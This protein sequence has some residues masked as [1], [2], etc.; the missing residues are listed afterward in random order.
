MKIVPHKLVARRLMVARAALSALL[1]ASFLIPAIPFTAVAAVVLFWLTLSSDKRS[2]RE[3]LMISAPFLFLGLVGLAMSG[4]NERY[5]ILKDVWYAAKIPILLSIGALIGRREN[6]LSQNLKN[7]LWICVFGALLSLVI[8]PFLAARDFVGLDPELARKVPLVI[9]VC[10]PIILERLR[11]AGFKFLWTDL[12]AFAIIV[13]ATL[14]ADSRIALIAL[15][16][17]VLAWA[18]MFSSLP[19]MAA[20]AILVVPVGLL[21]WNILPDY[22]GGEMTAFNKLKRSIE[23]IAFTNAF[24]TTAMIWNWRGF[25][26]FM[27]QQMFDHGDVWQKTFGFGLGSKVDI[28]QPI[29]ISQEMTVQFLP[30]LHN[31]YYFV[32]IKFGIVGLITY[33]LTLFE[34]SRRYG[35]SEHSNTIEVRILR[36]MILVVFAATAV[37]TGL[38]NKSEL[39]GITLLIGYFLGFFS[40]L[41][42][43]HRRQRAMP[44]Q[45]RGATHIAPTRSANP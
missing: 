5:D 4:E 7:I 45:Q 31:G 18:G 32:L 27:A 16:I 19:K 28:G 8:L 38:F 34:W 42:P 35:I 14:I 20:S 25:E 10:I 9:L 15:L 2:N 33:F 24:D 21:I 17:M 3:A 22:Q 44:L 23:E 39:H 41:R 29:Q 43:P 12:F 30:T 26:A 37:I 11:K 36:G 40:T 6:N 1:L 13:T